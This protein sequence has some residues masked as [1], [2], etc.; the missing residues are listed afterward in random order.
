MADEQKEKSEDQ[1]EKDPRRWILLVS[2]L[3]EV[4]IFVGINL[5]F[6][7]PSTV[8]MTTP[9]TISLTPPSSGKILTGVILGIV[10][11]IV[12]FAVLKKGLWRRIFLILVLIGIFVVI[13]S[14]TLPTIS[15]ATPS[16]WRIL[17]GGIVGIAVIVVVGFLLIYWW[18]APNNLFWT[19]VPEGRAKIIVRADEVRKILIQWKGHVLAKQAMPGQDI[20]VWDVVEGDSPKRCFGGLRFYGWWPLDDV[21]VYDFSWT[22]I[23][24]NGE[25]ETH[26]RETLDYVLLKEDIYLAVVN[27]AEDKELLP[28][29]IRLVLTIRVINPYKAVFVIQNWLEAAINRIMPAV[30]NTF[31]EDTYKDWISTEIDL[32]DRIINHKKTKEFLD[33]ECEK[34]YGIEVKAIEVIE[35]DPGEDYR[36]ATLAEY[37]AEREKA[38]VVIGAEAQKE[39]ILLEAGAERERLKK[40]AQGEVQRIKKVY[41]QIKEF[42]ELGKLLRTL[43]AMEKSPGEGSKWIIPLPGATDLISQVFPG[44]DLNSLTSDD[45]VKIREMIEKFQQEVPKKEIS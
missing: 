36:N 2:I 9:Q 44:K 33:E 42:G 21:Y 8:S 26:E 15:V 19:F 32:A 11:M 4:G 37:L 5:L 7:L 16:L 38:K 22:N 24:Q 28:V 1:K 25:V 41:E 13:S 29:D 17:A 27:N 39:K 43:E 18:W 12:G 14:L 40:V 45:I 3:I 20:D 23:A 30:R 10:G 34:G 6:L 35:I 31:T